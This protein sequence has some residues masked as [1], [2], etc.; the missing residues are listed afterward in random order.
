[1]SKVYRLNNDFAIECSSYENKSGKFH[2]VVIIQVGLWFEPV[3]EE[4][5]DIPSAEEANRVFKEMV[6]KYRKGI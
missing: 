5:C 6:S 1:M 3:V 4:I 2:R